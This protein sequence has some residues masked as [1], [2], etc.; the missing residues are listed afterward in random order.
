MKCPNKKYLHLYTD[1]VLSPDTKEYIHIKNCKKCMEEVNFYLNVANNIKSNSAS[2]P[3]TI[4]ERIKAKV[5]DKIHTVEYKET[6]N[7]I[8]EDDEIEHL[9]AAKKEIKPQ[10]NFDFLDKKE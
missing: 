2:I 1:G 10:D 4:L 3:K 6:N 9:A 7:Y 5:K 8:L